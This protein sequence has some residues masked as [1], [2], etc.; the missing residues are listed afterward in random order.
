ME[1]AW[2]DITVEESNLTVQISKLRQALGPTRDGTKWIVTVPRLGYRFAVA[3]ESFDRVDAAAD[4]RSSLAV[5]PFE[6]VSGQPEHGYIADGIT[7]EIITGLAKFSNVHVAARNSSFAYKGKAV[8]VRQ[9][10]RDLGVGYILEGSVS[11]AG[12]RLRVSGKLIDGAAGTHIWAD[13]FEGVV[14]DAFDAQDGLTECIVGAVEPSIRRA[15]IIRA[16]RKRPDRLDANDLFLRALPCV[17]ANTPGGTEGALQLLEQA[18]DLEPDHALARACASWCHEQRYLRGGFRSEDMTA[19]LE[20]AR[21]SIASGDPQAMSIGAFVQA[22]VTRDYETA[23][24]TLDR[25]LRLNGNSA[26]ALGFSAL[27]NAQGESHERAEAHALRALR[28]SPSD[29]LNYHSYGALALVF[30]FTGRFEQA[31][32]FSML[33]VQSN[34]G[35]SVFHALLV[36][37]FALLGRVDAARSAARRLLEVAPDF[38]IAG[39]VRMG[40]YPRPRMEQIAG[41]LHKAGLPE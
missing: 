8:D 2:P 39:F 24:G 23:A 36:A 32:T 30:L 22:N 27:V 21:R 17:Y 15:E 11:S 38:S 10:A 18:L 1:A 3:V 7:D 6:N 40:V 26:L 5:L 31:V 34:P 41:A 25:A 20:H 16:G 13:R 37:S 19:A 29:P 9:V 33:A 35:F 28:L 4:S 14:D 12:K